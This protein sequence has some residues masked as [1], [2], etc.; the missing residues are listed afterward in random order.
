RIQR[1]VNWI[2]RFYQQ[3]LYFDFLRS[4]PVNIQL[5]ENRAEYIRYVWDTA[6]WDASKTLGVYMPKTHSIV[7]YLHEQKTGGL[8][9]TYAT[10]LHEVSHAILHSLAGRLRNWLNEGM[11]EQMESLGFS[12]NAFTFTAHPR[13]KRGWLARR[14]QALPV[15][16]I[17]EL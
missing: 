5:L 9:S 14:Q 1:E 15:L 6:Q 7:L 17:V 3:T 13:N 2:Y 12:V 4:V 11:A 16:Q 8:E 10:I